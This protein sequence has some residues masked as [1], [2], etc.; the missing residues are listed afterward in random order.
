MIDDDIMAHP[1]AEELKRE[2]R[3]AKAAA[4]AFMR[5]C[6]SGDVEALY[7]AVDWLNV[8]IDGWPRAMRKV[9][10]HVQSVSP[11]IQEAFAEVWRESK[12]LPL[13]VGDNRAL[14]DAIRILL[15]PYHGPA[16]RLFRGAVQPSGAA[17]FT[18]CLGRRTLPLPRNSRATVR[19]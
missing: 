9:A 7:Q 18:V 5:A 1:F 3:E 15:P 12:M 16:V 14:C 13:H 8:T 4:D 2:A 10:R 17:E 19:L 11:D 6:Q